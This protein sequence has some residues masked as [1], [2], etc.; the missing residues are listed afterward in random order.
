M[1][2]VI[3]LLPEKP[4]TGCSASPEACWLPKFIDVDAVVLVSGRPGWSQ[5]VRVLPFGSPEEAWPVMRAMIRARLRHEYRIM[6]R[7][8]QLVK[9]NAIQR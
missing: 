3:A 1:R 5:Q 9:I 4:L 7:W 8:Q 2:A 6:G